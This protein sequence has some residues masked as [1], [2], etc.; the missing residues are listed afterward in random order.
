MFGG[1]GKNSS[2][3]LIEIRNFLSSVQRQNPNANQYEI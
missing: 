1:Q 2:M 3:F